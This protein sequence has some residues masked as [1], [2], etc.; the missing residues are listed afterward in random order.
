MTLSSFKHRMVGVTLVILLPLVFL[1]FRTNRAELSSSSVIINEI[2]YNAPDDV[3]DIQWIELFNPSGNP[4]D[5]G[6]WTIDEGKVFTFP[7]QTLIG[8][9]EFLVVALAPD[10]FFEVYSERAIGPLKRSLKRNG[11]KLTLRNAQGIKMDVVRYEEL[12]PWPVSADGYSASLERICPV[13]PGEIAENW[14]GS[15]LPKSPAPS[16]TPGKKNSIFSSVLPPVVTM[17]AAQTEA[18]PGE[19]LIV[20]ALVKG[21]SADPELFFRVVANGSEGEEQAVT[22]TRERGDRFVGVIPA[23]PAGSLVRYRVKAV[24]EG[25]GM[26]FFPGENDLRPTLSVYVHEEWEPA[27]IPFAIVLLGGEDK[28]MAQEPEPSAQGFSWPGGGQFTGRGPR[29]RLPSSSPETARPPRGASTLI[30]YDPDSQQTAVFDH[31]NAVPRED[32][33]GFKVYFQKD[34]TLDGMRAVNLVFEGSEWSLLAEHLAYDLYI[35]AGSPAPASRFVRVW[36]DGELVG[37]HLMVERINRSFL[38]RNQID[39]DGN[40][41][42]KVWMARDVIGQHEKKTNEQEGHEDLLALL[43]QLT[44]AAG[45]P[46]REWKVI[47]ENFDVDQVAT[48]F[49]VNMILSH[50][51]G[52]F[53]NY[54]AYHD[55]KQGKWQLYPWDQ[56]KTWGYYDFLPDDQVFFDMPLSFGMAGDR[57]PGSDDNGDSGNRSSFGF[58]GGRRPM[59]WREGGP[60]SQPLLANPQFREAFLVRTADILNRLYTEATYFPMI[61]GLVELLEEDAAIRARL[62]GDEDSSAAGLLAEYSDLLK[63][64]LTERRRFLWE[65]EELKSKEV[66]SPA[67]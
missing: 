41:Y 36:V 53:N 34:H 62:R 50:W 63:R 14:A 33:R 19:P 66:G 51:D 9:N 49:A 52:F 65:Q 10:R 1:A 55:T 32:G 12:P 11:E 67:P 58:G 13:A 64:H 30:Y 40:L 3:N 57:P 16:G 38:R 44:D 45:D 35:R 31:I 23:Q 48:Y 8:A 61:D 56:D 6:G 17:D 22:M 4:I 60:F 54:F 42:K 27:V 2:F 37:Y 18:V 25:G 26:R 20:E 15:P 29:P 43:D 5:L 46:E 59:W 7:E 21:N 39:D 24:G 28:A 47:Q